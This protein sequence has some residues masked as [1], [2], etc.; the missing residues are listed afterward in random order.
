MATV[1]AFIKTTQKKKEVFVRFRLSIGKGKIF[2]H[3]S[4]LTILP[5]LWD[6]M[7]Q[8]YKAKCLVEPSKRVKFD[9]AVA[10]RSNLILN[11]CLNNNITSSEEL[12]RLIDRELN[13]DKYNDDSLL[14]RFKKYGKESFAH[15]SINEGR[16]NHLKVIEGDIVMFMQK[17]AIDNINIVEFNAESILKF[18]EFLQNGKNNSQNTIVG[19]LKILQ[20]FLNEMEAMDIIQ[21]SPFRKLGKHRKTSIFRT[22][23]DEPIALRKDEFL[24][25][26]S[27]SC[28]DNLIETK[29][30]FIVQCSLG[31]RIGDFSRLSYDNIDYDE[32]IPFVHYLPEKTSRE[33]SFRT[34]I[35]TPL[36][37]FAFDIIEKYGFKFPILNYPSG[38][39]GYNQ[40]IKDLL[41][42]ADINR[43]V[44]AG[45]EYV[46]LWLTGSSKLA[47]K[48]HIDLMNKVQIDK[49]VAGLHSDK[50]KAVDRY[51][52]M[53]I[54][55][56][57]NLMLTAF[58][59]SGF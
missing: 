56:R 40:K 37:P 19:K 1:T 6:E 20:A 5:D 53:S 12:N 38:K 4:N 7:G 3:K 33:L 28:P 59:D 14:E 47:R 54:K 18:R 41:R 44:Y 13:P 17:N 39:S 58:H 11:L 16:Y 52:N 21:V 31:C 9:K 49:Y 23:Y 24:R 22:Q 30:A 32:G 50:S 55:D 35:K 48:T 42:Y 2:F 25:L 15:H 57:Y 51:I 34:E 27:I 10:E 45:N 8:K 43:N 46:P 36:L 26:L 29:D